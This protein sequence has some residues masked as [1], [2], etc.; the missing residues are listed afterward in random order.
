MQVRTGRD[1]GTPDLCDLVTTLDRLSDPGRDLAR[2][3]K[4]NWN[5]KFGMRNGGR[6]FLTEL[7]GTNRLVS[8]GVS[9]ISNHSLFRTPNSKLRIFMRSSSRNAQIPP[10]WTN[11]CNFW[12]ISNPLPV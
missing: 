1:T 3:T 8:G 4:K 2:E 5:G 9:L 7:R 6:Y 12:T 10:S 11:E